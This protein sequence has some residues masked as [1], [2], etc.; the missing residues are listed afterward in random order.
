ME[1]W[2]AIEETNGTY[3]VSNKGNVVN[4]KTGRYIKPAAYVNGYFAAPLT[5]NGKQK[6]FRVHRLVA[7]Y[8]VPNPMNYPQVNHKDENKGNNQA[9]NLEWCTAQYNVNYGTKIQRTIE[10]LSIKVNQY[11]L[12]GK[13]VKQYPSIS[14]AAREIGRDESS[15]RGACNGKRLTCA[16]YKWKKILNGETLPLNITF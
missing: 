6:K 1:I 12:D 2:K 11:S 16:G 13:L 3:S 9:D 7:K 10:K 8:F 4:N 14:E 15:V 5:V